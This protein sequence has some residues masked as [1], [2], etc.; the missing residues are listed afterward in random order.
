MR[1]SWSLEQQVRLAALPRAHW[2]RPERRLAW[3]VSARTQH[4]RS[5]ASSTCRS[6]SRTSRSREHAGCEPLEQL[7]GVADRTGTILRAP[8]PGARGLGQRTVA[9]RRTTSPGTAA[10]RTSRPARQ[11]DRERQFACRFD[12]AAGRRMGVTG[13]TEWGRLRTQ[14]QHRW[15][16]QRRCEEHPRACWKGSLATVGLSAVHGARLD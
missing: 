3:S 9:P 16:P 12:R 6:Q 10:R 5:R 4:V 8:S 13:L 11:A 15:P 1:P 2:W 14:T 7:P